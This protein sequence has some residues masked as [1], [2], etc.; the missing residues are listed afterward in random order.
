MDSSSSKGAAASNSIVDDFDDWGSSVAAKPAAA[1]AAPSRASL[2]G[3]K[4]SDATDLLSFSPA[5]P[6]AATAHKKS[7]SALNDPFANLSLS[8]ASASSAS[9][10]P[11][12]GV[13]SPGSGG[14]SLSLKARPAQA[15][16]IV[17]SAKSATTAG[18][19]K[20]P[21]SKVD[22]DWGSFLNS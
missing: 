2:H 1:A 12:M 7:P 16:P 21:A 19:A 6:T 9:P 15:T 20:K 17:L 10:K 3:K 14:G 11:A 18:A 8:S 13:V 5:P 4:A 22:D